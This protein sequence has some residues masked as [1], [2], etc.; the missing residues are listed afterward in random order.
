MMEAEVEGR[1][2]DTGQGVKLIEARKSKG[3]DSPL[4]PAKGMQPYRCLDFKNSYLQNVTEY[5]CVV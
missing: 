4:E 5:I 1:E 2:G 3:M